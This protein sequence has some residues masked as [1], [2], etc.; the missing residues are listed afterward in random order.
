MRARCFCAQAAPSRTPK[1][2]PRPTGT[3]QTRRQTT[4]LQRLGFRVSRVQIPP[5]R[6][7]EDQALQRLS[8]W[9]FGKDGDPLN[10][11]QGVARCESC[12]DSATILGGSPVLF[13]FTRVVPGVA[14]PRAAVAWPCALHLVVP[15]RCDDPAI[16]RR[17]R[18]SDETVRRSDV[19]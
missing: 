1:I 17:M 12:C 18:W 5:S 6:L 19:C 3:G 11:A 15:P 2:P 13:M 8:L 7:S 4:Q 9:G 14:R 16:Q 10:S